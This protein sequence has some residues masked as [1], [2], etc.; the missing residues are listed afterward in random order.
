MPQGSRDGFGPVKR[1]ASV[2]VDDSIQEESAIIKSA[3]VSN[4]KKDGSH[5]ISEESYL[6]DDFD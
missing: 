3:S 6:K 2:T 4:S 1:Q 5:E